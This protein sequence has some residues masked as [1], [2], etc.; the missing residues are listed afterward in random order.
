M[1]NTG[2]PIGSDSIL[3]LY[4][5][6]SCI[7]NYVNS[8][9]DSFPDRFGT[10]RLTLAGLIKRSMALRNEI[11]DFSGALTFKPEWSDVPMNVSEGVGGEG[12]ALNLQAE[13]LGNRSEIN[14]ITSREAL[15]R[16][17]QEVGLNLVEGSFEQGGVLYKLT[18]VLLHEADGEVYKWLG[19]FPEDGKVIMRGSTPIS[20]GGV[21]LSTWEALSHT[22]LRNDI[23]ASLVNFKPNALSLSV[24]RSLEDILEELLSIE[25]LEQSDLINSFQQAV[26]KGIKSFYIPPKV[27]E[28]DNSTSP[29]VISADNVT[30]FGPGT[31]KFTRYDLSGIYVTG[32]NCRLFDFGVEGPGDVD[33]TYPGP[34]NGKFNAFC[35]GLISLVGIKDNDTPSELNAVVDGIRVKNPGIK[36]ISAYK[37]LDFKITNCKLLSQYPIE[38]LFG[39]PQFFGISV[40]TCANFDVSN[41]ETKGFSQG[42]SVGAL[43]SGYVFDDMLGNSYYT[44]RHFTLTHNR[45][46]SC[47]DHGIYVSNDVSNYSVTDNYL[48]PAS[49]AEKGAGGGGLKLEGGFFN[50]IGNTCRDGIV[51]RNVYDCNISNNVVPVYSP[52]GAVGNG[53]VKWGIMHEETVFK[54]P[55]KNVSITDNVLSVIGDIPTT[56]AIQFTGRVWDN[57]QSVISNLKITGNRASGFGRETQTDP[58]LGVGYGIY[59]G[60]QL[61]SSNGVV[62]DTPADT[63]EISYNI[64]DMASGARLGSYGVYLC[65]AIDNA[66]VMGNNLRGMTK[67]GVMS[68]GVR[69]SLFLGNSVI[70]AKGII[71]DIAFEERKD[72]TLALHVISQQNIYGVNRVGT[73]YPAK[74]FLANETSRI[75]DFAGTIVNLGA[76]T[77]VTLQSYG[78][79]EIVFCNPSSPATIT[80]GTAMVWPIGITFTIVNGGT[81][82]ITINRPI[83]GT[84]SI[85]VGASRKFICLGGNN[86][87]VS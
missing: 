17:Y 41:N 71:S 38:N 58:G 47:N 13:A 3:D 61:L 36:G 14:K 78:I 45:V 35:P 52:I 28:L 9:E 73:S 42:I 49:S 22:A 12:G 66:V 11:N 56:G 44:S 84:V 64:I 82:D 76:Q 25:S 48:W 31:L 60:Q 24:K 15:R 18:D 85:P 6:S 67:Q 26:D 29:L 20:T 7:D 32:K 80:L 87:V 86:I 40:Y 65:N 19:E 77:S 54:R 21:N 2:N 23:D 10:K 79:K 27:Y 37:A 72:D 5:N 46:F 81:A 70:P 53:N 69:K 1:H 34:S 16:T 51:L 75:D 59:V 62:I 4:D 43:G 68:L 33:P 74:Y 50:A 57:Y 39:K 30:I 63:V 8:Q 83:G 55:A